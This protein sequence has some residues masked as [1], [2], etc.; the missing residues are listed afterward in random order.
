MAVKNL[1]FVFIF[2]FLFGFLLS[3]WHTERTNAERHDIHV[4]EI[5]EQ[6][7][8]QNIDVAEW[9]IFAKFSFSQKSKKVKRIYT[10]FRQFNWS[11]L[12]S[13]NFEKWTGTYYNSDKQITET[14]QIIKPHAKASPKIQVIYEAT[15]KRWNGRAWMKLERYFNRHIF[16]K[17]PG[18]PTFF[19]CVKGY[20][21]DKMKGVLFFEA[22]NLL[23]RFHAKPV[24]S[25][26]EQRF[27]SI[28]GFTNDWDH[29][30]KTKNG[31]MNIQ[32]SLRS[33]GMGERTTV[34]VGTPIITT[35]Y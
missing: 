20:T 24:E 16:D 22:N 4:E 35:E 31:K 13:G 2:I 1:Y 15:G 18:N 21:D 34:T 5:V 14:L 32:I 33:A 26:N 10:Q 12:E 28:S 17:I 25:L 6:F 9:S 11:Y 29:S 19:T 3:V 27:V 30:I 23:K 8:Q 7:Q